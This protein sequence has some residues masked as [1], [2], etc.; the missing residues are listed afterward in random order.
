MLRLWTNF[1]KTGDPNVP[2]PG[3]V[4]WSPLTDESQSFL[5]L[6]PMEMTMPENYHHRTQFW[7]SVFSRPALVATAEGPVLGSFLTT[8]S[9]KTIRS[10]QGIPYA[11]PP[12]GVLRFAPLSQLKYV[13]CSMTLEALVMHVLKALD[14]MRCLRGR[15]RTASS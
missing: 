11:S 10:F 5:D 3:P 1:A 2:E 8:V 15:V 12:V 6:G 13:T 9:G 14:L 4:S 7:S